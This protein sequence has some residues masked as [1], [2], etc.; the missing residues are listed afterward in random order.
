MTVA[1]GTIVPV[2]VGVTVLL[3]VIGLLTKLRLRDDENTDATRERLG[4]AGE[5]Q[6]L[7][8]GLG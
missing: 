6:E 7:L 1:V 8:W 5:N 4:T 2:G 3:V